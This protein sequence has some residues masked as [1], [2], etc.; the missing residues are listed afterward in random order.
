MPRP[1]KRVIA[2]RTSGAVGA[3]KRRRIILRSEEIP[4]S[5][6][7]G[8]ALSSSSSNE[9]EGGVIEDDPEDDVLVLAQPE[10][11][12]KEAE[13]RL[14]G[15]SKT[16]TGKTKQSRWH[17]AQQKKKQEMEKVE[18]QK[19]YGNISPGRSPA[20]SSTPHLTTPLHHRRL[21]SVRHGRTP[22][23]GCLP[24]STQHSFK[25]FPLK[26]ISNSSMS[27]VRHTRRS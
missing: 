14:P 19:T 6:S 4:D 27:G 18:L 2:T 5:C 10:G 17:H 9:A 12:W 11:G 26:K 3:Q 23:Q 16:N 22:L 7:D 13:R 15:Y 24:A 1:S 21:H 25:P 8:S 20:P